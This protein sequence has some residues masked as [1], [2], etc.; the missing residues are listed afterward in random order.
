LPAS[1]ASP[2]P[3]QLSERNTQSNEDQNVGASLLAK[4]RYQSLDTL[5]DPPHSRASP[6]PQGGLRLTDR[7]Y[8]HKATHLKPAQRTALTPSKVENEVSLAVSKKSRM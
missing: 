1:L 6:L 8:S 7:H 2:D 5:T 3:G 4:A